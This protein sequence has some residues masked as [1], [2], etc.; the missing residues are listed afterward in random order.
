MQTSCVSRK[1]GGHDMNA[2]AVATHV[3]IE[4][5]CSTKQ[6]IHDTDRCGWKFLG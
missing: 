2:S 6:L 1:H 3:Q 4:T 5:S